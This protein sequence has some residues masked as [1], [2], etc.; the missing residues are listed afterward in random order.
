VNKKEFIDSNAA[1]YD[2]LSRAAVAWI[3]GSIIDTLDTEMER[4]RRVQITGFGTSATVRRK[5]RM[6]RN[7]KTGKAIKA[8][9]TTVPKF[10]A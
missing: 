5:A 4:G 3:V 10:S 1:Q 6:G 7:L 9:A 2:H 8:P